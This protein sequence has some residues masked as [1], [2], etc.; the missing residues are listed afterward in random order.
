MWQESERGFSSAG[1][2]NK[3]SAGGMPALFSSA[4]KISDADAN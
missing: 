4:E 2:E 3:K 1:H